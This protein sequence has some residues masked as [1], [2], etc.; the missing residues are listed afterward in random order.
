MFFVYC[1]CVSISTMFLTAVYSI[2]G[3][4][5]WVDR[6][7]PW[8]VR[9]GNGFGIRWYELAYLAGLLLAGWVFFPMGTLGAVGQT[10]QRATGRHLSVGAAGKTTSRCRVTPARSTRPELKECFC[11]SSPSGY[12][13]GLRD[14]GSPL[15]RFSSLMEQA[16]LSMSSGGNRMLASR[17]TGDG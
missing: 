14:R 6:L 15:L 2:V 1:Y 16:A 5:D 17:S 11:F 3:Q 9:F 4:H 10:G 13:G 7:N 8:V 12:W